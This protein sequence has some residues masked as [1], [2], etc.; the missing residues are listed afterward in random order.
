MSGA[1]R[2]RPYFKAARQLEAG[3]D[4]VRDELVEN[5]ELDLNNYITTAFAA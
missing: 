2:C 1:R 3:N 5:L 4:S